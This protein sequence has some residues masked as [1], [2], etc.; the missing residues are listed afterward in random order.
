M[1]I[2]TLEPLERRHLPLIVQ[3]R[4]NDAVR[5]HVREVRILSEQD[6]FEWWASLA[7]DPTRTFMMLADSSEQFRYCGVGGFVRWNQTHR[8]AELSVLVDDQTLEVDAI[9]TLC[10][11]GFD[12]LNLHRIEAECWTSARTAAFRMAGF[13]EDGTRRHGFYRDGAWGDAVL[14]SLLADD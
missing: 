7:G 2:V 5:A 6:V 3:W 9:E 11:F 8:H 13:T 4:A 10:A 1:S 14:L 12:R